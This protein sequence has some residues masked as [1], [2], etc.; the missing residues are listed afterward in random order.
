VYE[1]ALDS[2]VLPTATAAVMIA[3]ELFAGLIRLTL[4]RCSYA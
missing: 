4:D 2:G 3:G 1:N